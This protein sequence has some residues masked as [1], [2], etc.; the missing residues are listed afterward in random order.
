MPECSQS[1]RGL[2][3]LLELRQ[4]GYIYMEELTRKLATMHPAP[5]VERMDTTS[6]TVLRI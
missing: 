3:E 1:S 2:M 6:I 5:K 4:G